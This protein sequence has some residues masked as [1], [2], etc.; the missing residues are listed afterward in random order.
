MLTGGCLPFFLHARL[1]LAAPTDFNCWI[2]WAAADTAPP[3]ELSAY[4]GDTDRVILVD[5][6]GMTGCGPVSAEWLVGAHVYPN[7][8]GTGLESPGAIRSFEGREQLLGVAAIAITYHRS[9]GTPPV[10]AR[11][12]HGIVARPRRPRDVGAL[13]LRLRREHD[14][15]C[16]SARRRNC[17]RPRAGRHVH[18]TV[19]PAKQLRPPLFTTSCMRLAASSSGFSS[20]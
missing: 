6:R 9:R 18:R 4:V 1:S 13:A 11:H 17:G 15:G 2:V 8:G 14:R 16:R 10:R 12:S 3:D 19:V 20:R 7:S 5:R